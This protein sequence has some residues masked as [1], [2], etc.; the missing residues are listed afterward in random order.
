MQSWAMSVP[1][2]SSLEVRVGRCCRD[3]C[4]G[5]RGERCS[6]RRR[7]CLPCRRV[8]VERAKS[9]WAKRESYLLLSS[10]GGL[11][12]WML[13]SGASS[14]VAYQALRY[15]AAV[16][17]FGEAAVDLTSFSSSATTPKQLQTTRCGSSAGP[18]RATDCHRIAALIDSH[19]DLF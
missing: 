16:S 18:I 3:C 1:I 14:F 4:R 9:R 5:S 12:E 13:V 17:Q 6:R 11:E 7:S 10:L 2:W 8:V 19:I 15:G